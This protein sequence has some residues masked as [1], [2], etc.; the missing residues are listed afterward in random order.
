M[1]VEVISFLTDKKNE[2]VTGTPSYGNLCGQLL[3][4]ESRHYHTS[5]TTCPPFR[6]T[7]SSTG[8]LLTVPS[9]LMDDVCVLTKAQV[10][11]VKI[12]ADSV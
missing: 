9:F 8:S 2:E 4:P 3:S 12:V 5:F 6:S 10:D 11:S 7:L 1:H